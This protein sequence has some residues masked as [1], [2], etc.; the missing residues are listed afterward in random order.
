[1]CQECGKAFGK[2]STL[3]KHVKTVHLQDYKYVWGVFGTVLV[4][5]SPLSNANCLILTPD[6]SAR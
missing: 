6:T 2:A 5:F 3:N 1:M 4:I